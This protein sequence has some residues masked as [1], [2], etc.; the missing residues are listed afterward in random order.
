M[1]GHTIKILVVEDELEIRRFLHAS[2]VAHGYG[3]VEA[4]TGQDGLKQMLGAQPDLLLLDLG[5]PDLDGVEV[6]R[7]LRQWSQIPIIVI[8]GAGATPKK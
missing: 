5:L 7:R 2:L 8:S 1:E 4:E 3:L 6:I